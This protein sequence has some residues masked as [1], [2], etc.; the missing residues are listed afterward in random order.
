MFFLVI[1]ETVDIHNLFRISSLCLQLQRLKP[2]SQNIPLKY[3]VQSLA[4][5]LKTG[6]VLALTKWELHLGC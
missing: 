2:I 6:A 4:G 5:G 3:F 1:N